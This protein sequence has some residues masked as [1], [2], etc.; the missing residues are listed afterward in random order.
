MNKSKHGLLSIL[1]EHLKR[2][3]LRIED[4]DRQLEETKTTVGRLQGEVEDLR[5]DLAGKRK[6]AT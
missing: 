6:G 5:K 2:E 3:Q 1:D 4:R